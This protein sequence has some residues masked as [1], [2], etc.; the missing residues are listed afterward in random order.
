MDIK[1]LLARYTDE[2]EF[3]VEGQIRWLQKQ[4]FTQDQIDHAIMTVYF[5]LERHLLPNKWTLPTGEIVYLPGD[6]PKTSDDWVGGEISG[7]NDLDQYLL[8]VSK[9]IR[10]KELSDKA[11]QLGG[12]VQKMKDQW[13]ADA[14]ARAK[15][16]GFFK[17]MFS[18]AE[19]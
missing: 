8:K 14:I 16:P 4:G 12:L 9:D 7:G 11:A 1:A 17:R 5:D 10:T 13:E 2:K 3:T 19:A 15:K 6:Q 18:K